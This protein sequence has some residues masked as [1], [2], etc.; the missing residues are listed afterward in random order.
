MRSNCSPYASFFLLCSLISFSCHCSSFLYR[1]AQKVSKVLTFQI[2]HAILGLISQRCIFPFKCQF[3]ILK[4]IEKGLNT[5]P[6]SFDFIQKL[7]GKQFKCKSLWRRGLVGQSA[8]LVNRRSWVQIPVVPGSFVLF[9]LR[10]PSWPENS[11]HFDPICNE[12]SCASNPRVNATNPQDAFSSD[13]I[14]E[15]TTYS[16][17]GLH[18][19]GAVA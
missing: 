7:T 15:M 14:Q 19:I 10:F 9:V 13:P 8:C 18:D 11:N 2:S 5:L 3:A 4:Y 16:T 1:V 6:L 17:N 12:C